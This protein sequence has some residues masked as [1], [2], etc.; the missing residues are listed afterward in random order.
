MR[1]VEKS[2]VVVEIVN[3]KVNQR[4]KEGLKKQRKIRK[5]RMRRKVQRNDC[6]W[7]VWIWYVG[8]IGMLGV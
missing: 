2:L 8:T 3:I 1:V 4:K 5:K 6:G 7:E